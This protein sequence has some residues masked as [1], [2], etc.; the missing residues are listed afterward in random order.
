MRRSVLPLIAAALLAGTPEARPAFRQ[1][2][3]SDTTLHSGSIER[4]TYA[5]GRFEIAGNLYLPAAAERPCPA[6]MWVSGSGPSSRELRNPETRRVV[7][8]FLDS[9]VAY[10]RVDK[11]G[12]GDSRGTVDD[13]STFVQLARIVVDG[14]RI[15]R[16]H[17]A[18][19]SGRIGLFGSSQ[20]GYIMPIA[21]TRSDGIAFMIGSSCPA[22]NSIEQWNYL[23]EQQLLC[24]RVPPEKAG[25]MAGMFALL[26]STPDSV[27]FARAIGYFDRNP[28]IVPSL[29][30]D[31]SFSRKAR[32]WW[33]RTIDSADESHFDPMTLVEKIAIPIYMAYGGR[34][35]Q[36]DPFQG[37]EGYRAACR[38]GGNQSPRTVLLPESDHNMHVS[39][40]CLDEMASLRNR[41]V[42]RVDPEYLRT[43]RGWVGEV[44]RRLRAPGQ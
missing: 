39:G 32:T 38:R 8:C 13:E 9:G 34:D 31:S 18:I 22:E 19:D 37:M 16:A 11:P 40:G 26:R 25:E 2:A 44:K 10:F 27:Q 36:I 17:P 29:G 23:L 15:L 20:A 3:G 14:V 30:Y 35:T 5:S 24:R 12:S 4:I 43:L 1:E 21:I 6:V 7:N 41:G 33:P 28:M 42:Y